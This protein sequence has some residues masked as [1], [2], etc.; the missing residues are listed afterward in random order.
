[1]FERYLFVLRPQGEDRSPSV[2]AWAGKVNA[3][4]KRVDA[5]EASLGANS[6]TLETKIDEKICALE[7]KIDTKFAQV[8]QA[9]E[10]LDL[11]QRAD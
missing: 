11:L 9:L 4:V 8:L 7:A 5:L 1:M 6:S 2:D 3:I 10:K